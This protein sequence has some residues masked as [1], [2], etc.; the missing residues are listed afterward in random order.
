MLITTACQVICIL[1]A[2]QKSEKLKEEQREKPKQ[3]KQSIKLRLLCIFLTLSHN[4]KR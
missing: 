2:Q 4:L 3:T 1:A